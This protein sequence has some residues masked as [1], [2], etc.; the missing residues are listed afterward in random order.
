MTEPSINF[1]AKYAAMCV[2]VL[3]I[4][5]FI[6][7]HANSKADNCFPCLLYVFCFFLL[8]RQRALLLHQACNFL[9]VEE[10][11]R[12]RR[13]NHVFQ[14]DKFRNEKQN[15]QRTRRRAW[16]RPSPRN[17][18]RSLLANPALNFL[19]KKHFHLLESQASSK[20]VVRK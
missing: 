9:V 5:A 10:E 20:Q 2:S 11:F 15:T 17:W 13:R 1:H 18:F 8:H 3:N 12:V 4:L 7:H 6:L 19:W 14:S 16:L